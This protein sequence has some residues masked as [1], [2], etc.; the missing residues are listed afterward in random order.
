[1]HIPEGCITGR[2]VSEDKNR[3]LCTVEIDG[4]KVSA[5]GYSFL[6]WYEK[7]EATASRVYSISTEATKNHYQYLF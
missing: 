2:F 6:G 3:F 1:M 4:A 7:P 5:N